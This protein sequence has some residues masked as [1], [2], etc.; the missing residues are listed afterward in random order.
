MAVVLAY[1]KI[2]GD[3]DKVKEKAMGLSKKMAVEPTEPV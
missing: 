1:D 3:V 2:G